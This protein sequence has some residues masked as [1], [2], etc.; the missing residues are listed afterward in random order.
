MHD[1]TFSR[2]DWRVSTTEAAPAEAAIF[3]RPAFFHLH[4]AARR[5]AFVSL[6]DTARGVALASMHFT[7]G[8]DGVFH[9]PLRGTFAGP[10]WDPSVTCTDLLEFLRQVED[11][12]R[13][14]PG[15]RRLVVR[16][17]SVLSQRGSS[18]M[19]VH[20]LL[21]LGFRVTA[22]DLSY[23]MDVTS[24]PFVDGVD[25]GNAKRLRKLYAS[26]V[27][28]R[29]LEP[30]ALPACHAIIAANRE[31]RGKPMTMD[32]PALQRMMDT[33][34]SETSLWGTQREGTLIAAAVCLRLTPALEYVAYWGDAPDVSTLSPTTGLAEAIHAHAKATGAS[35]LDLG[36][37]TDAGRPDTGL[38][39]YKQNLGCSASLK[40]QL[41]K[42]IMGP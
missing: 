3:Q 19:A 29:R 17:P 13:R 24:H 38:M 12:V 20:A 42:D 30:H 35:Y 36:V 25:R 33:F 28:T 2:P 27:T 22:S 16:L 8:A 37:S 21:S 18:S 14:F 11:H 1:R 34:P 5:S 40:L 39:R 7:E 31:R 41:E 23:G 6:M 15:A 26:G 10:C 4:N 9:S 32:L